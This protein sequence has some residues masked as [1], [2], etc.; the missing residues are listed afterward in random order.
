MNKQTKIK[1]NLKQVLSSGGPIV[2]DLGCGAKKKEG[3]IGIDSVDLP[4]V[5]IVTDIEQGLPFL[6]EKSVDEIYC[7][8]VLEHVENF[9]LL[10][11]EMVRVLKK[12]GR[13]HIYVPHFSNPYYYSDYTHRRFFGLYTFYYFVEEHSQLRRKVPIFYSNVRIKILRLKLKFRSPFWFCDKVKKLFG[14]FVNLCDFTRELYE[15]SFCYICPCDGIELIFAP[16]DGNDS[17]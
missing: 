4:N 15:Q 16:V 5:D 8:S 6:P 17:K 12:Q 1:F 7:R 9:E 11:R 14:W 10:M 2:I 13:A 3:T